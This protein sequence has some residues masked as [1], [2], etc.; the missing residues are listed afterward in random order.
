MK[1]FIQLPM[2]IG[3]AKRFNAD[4]S[5]RTEIYNTPRIFHTPVRAIGQ[6]QGKHTEYVQCLF[7]T[8]NGDAHIQ[9]VRRDKAEGK[10]LI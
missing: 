8:G 4:G 3:T 2:L 6:A 10:L 9:L 1:N 5:Q 7:P